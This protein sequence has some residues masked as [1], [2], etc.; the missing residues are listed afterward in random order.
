MSTLGSIIWHGFEGVAPARWGREPLDIFQYD[1][2]GKDFGSR[3]CS[4]L[5]PQFD[6]I[7]ANVT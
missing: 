7:V 2:E 6:V 5:R 1:M 4:D 3:S